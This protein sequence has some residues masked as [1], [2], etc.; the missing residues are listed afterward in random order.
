MVSYKLSFAAERDL[1]RLYQFGIRNFGLDRA[2]RYFDDLF[3]RFER[4]GVQPQLYPAIDYIRP[5]YRRSVFG[6][7]SIYY[8]DQNGMVEIM[9]ILG[10][11]NLDML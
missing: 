7:H 8:R 1:R 2:D 9:R 11:E 3:E 4:I 5:G 10:R 6:A